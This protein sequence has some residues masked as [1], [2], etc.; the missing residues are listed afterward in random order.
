[1]QALSVYPAPVSAVG[2]DFLLR[3]IN[4]TTDAVPILTRLVRRQLVRFHQGSYY[5][6]PVDRDYAR[7][8]LSLGSPGDPPAAFTLAVLQARA[9]DYYA[10]IRTPRESWRSLEDVR[11]QLAE[12]E[13]RCDTGDYDTAATVLSDIDFDYLRVW[14]HYGTLVELNGRIHGRITDPDLN[15]EHLTSLGLCHL[16]L[17]DYRQA[18]GLFTQALAIARDLGN[19]EGEGIQL[20]NLGTCHMSL[21]DYWQAIDLLTQALAIA[22]DLGDREGEG[23]QLG[24][25]GLCHQRLGDYQQ[26]IDLHTQALAIARDIGNRQ[27]E[28]S[29]LGNLGVCHADLGDYRQA[30]GLLTQALA[31]ARDIGDRYNE[32]NALNYLGRAWLASDD[33]RQGMTLLEQAVSVADATGDIE[34]AVEARSGLARAQLQLGDPAAALAATTARRQLPFPTEEPMMRLLEGLALLELNHVDEAARAFSDALR[35]ADALLAVA[36]RNVAAL[37]ARALAFSGLAAA[38]GES[39]RRT[40]AVEAF[41]RA[42]RV[43]S[44]AGVVAATHRLLDAIVSRDRSGILAEVR[45]AQGL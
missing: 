11:P 25:L 12:F 16:S 24:N 5:L 21:G 37:Q 41:A 20:G 35:A 26:A 27:F 43:T 4:P 23:T 29:R 2:V 36:D 40:E 13:L 34:P 7:S 28:G 14:G 18:I 44:A 17:G 19:R 33:V 22:R 1:M 10:Q 45:A 9:A 30:I 32:A 39:A 42:N 3:P 31:I 15:V 6:H 8:Q 38:S